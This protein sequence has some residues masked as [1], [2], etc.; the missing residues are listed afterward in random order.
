MA[1]KRTILL[2]GGNGFLGSSLLRKLVAR[3][4]SVLMTARATSDLSRIADLKDKVRLL[5]IEK[6]D[7]SE[8]FRANKIDAVVHCATNYGRKGESPLSVLEANLLL[9]LKLLQLGSE[10]GLSCFIN[11]DTV[12]D[13][14]ISP[15]ALSKAQFKEWL[16][17]YSARMNC[18]NV[19]LE[20]FYGPGDDSSKFST[21][22]IQ[23]LVKGVE[24]L[25]LTPGEQRRDFIYIDD[26]VEAM[27]TVVERDL[28]PGNGY[29]S[30]EVGTGH[31]VPIKDFVALA[32]D[33]SGNIS[34]ALNFGAL[35]YRDKEVMESITDRAA[36][37][38]LGWSP[39]VPLKEGLSK[40]IE[41]EK[42]RPL[43]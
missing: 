39:K 24:K 30:Y 23:A 16:K 38:A 43:P 42:R 41:F 17:F 20:H 40:T 6:T 25:D 26:A 5:Y 21:W 8:V 13:K 34:T 14:G 4:F 3:D 15:Y 7:F 22:V 11:T 27:L 1:K 35:P 33:L 28:R 18:S 32:K 36:I 2:T 9:P 12:L 10:Y 19:A 37:L 31:V 29:F